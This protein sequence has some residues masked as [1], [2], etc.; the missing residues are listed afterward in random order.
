M[1][2]SESIKELAAALS[3]AQSEIV[4]AIKDS[5][6]PFFKSSYADLA[7]VWDA[8]REQLT[9][10]GLSIVQMPIRTPGGGIGLETAIMH[11]SGEWISEEFDMTPVK[12]DPQGIGSCITYMRRYALA[13]FAGVPQIDDDGNG[14]SGK[15]GNN[16]S[17]VITNTS[18]VTI[19]QKTKDDVYR[20]SV[21]AIAASDEVGLKQVWGE[22]DVDEKAVLWGLFNSQQRKAMKL[23]MEIK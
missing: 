7:S 12:A 14:A 15:E 18:N 10:N 3:K 5:S 16:T 23:L 19:T 4:G 2:K 9:K 17:N 1:N 22:F 6:N 8:C 11:S 21:A 20:Q 13:A